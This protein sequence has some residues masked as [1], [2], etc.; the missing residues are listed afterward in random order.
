MAPI[1]TAV[2]FTFKP[3]DAIR[4]AQANTHNLVP[5]NDMFRLWLQLFFAPV[6]Y[7]HANREVA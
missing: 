1:I 3:M 6:Q 5:L 4:M 2:E 7:L